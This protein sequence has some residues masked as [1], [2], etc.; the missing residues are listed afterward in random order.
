M[1]KEI[2][3]VFS[4]FMKGMESL[5][6]KPSIELICLIRLMKINTISSVLDIFASYIYNNVYVCTCIFV[7]IA[8]Q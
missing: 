3:A 2:A 1:V 4:S 6:C 5:L 7:N 8:L